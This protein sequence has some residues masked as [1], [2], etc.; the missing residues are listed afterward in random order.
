MNTNNLKNLFAFVAL[1]GL[2]GCEQ[3]IDETPQTSNV[4]YFNGQIT[5][6]NSE[7]KYALG[8]T[9][10]FSSHFQNQLTDSKSKEVTQLENETFML[11]GTLFLLKPKYDSLLFV[12]DNF[13]LVEDLGSVNL[14]NVINTRPEEYTFEIKFGKPL[15]NNS[16][17]FGL[18]LNYKAIF[19]IEYDCAVFYGSD[20]TDYDDFSTENNKDNIAISFNTKNVN[21][22]IFNALPSEYFNYYQ[23]YYNSSD[24]SANKFFFIE[25][26]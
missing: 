2:L 3:N 23:S 8:D 20:R 12:Y 22:S 15:I 9:I 10:W 19:A 24:I 5:V 4:K 25:V 18:V 13:N 21:D 1:I 16:V 26:D 6:E 14:I 17:R 7:F 11:N